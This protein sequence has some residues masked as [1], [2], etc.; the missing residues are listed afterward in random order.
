MRTGKTADNLHVIVSHPAKQGNIYYR[1]RAAQAMGASV[2][3]LTGL[4]YRPDRLPYSLV[5]FLPAARRARMERLL[6]K[7]RIEGLSP[8]NVTTL[9]GPVLET[10]MRPM[11]KVREWFAVH[12]WLASRWLVRH[13]ARRKPVPTILHTFQEAARRTLTAARR[14]DVVRL[15]EVTLPPPPPDMPDFPDAKKSD[16]E[17]LKE[18]VDQAEFVL[19]QSEFSARCVAALGFAPERIIRCHL[20]V[21]TH[22]FR[23]RTGPRRPGPVRVVFLGGTSRRKGVHHLLQAWTELRLEGAEL[24][25]A[26]NRTGGLENAPDLPNC[27]FL[28]RIPD[29]EFL[30]FLQDADVLVHPSLAEG[31]CNV[32]YEALACGIPCIISTNASSAVRS[33]QEGFVFPTGNVPALK[34]ALHRVCADPELRRQMSETARKRAETL[35]W[36][37]YLVRLAAIYRGLA[38]YAAHRDNC[39]LQELHTEGF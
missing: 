34:L 27:R 36:E 4:Y 29:E 37:K 38:D 16:A 11:R 30:T 8:E 9:L 5:R 17:R 31:G 26:G 22:H 23:P 7:R 1:P 15:F 13:M 39:V 35:A 6:E 21:D 19:V 3:F 18:E 32:V 20:G 10:T 25:I 33:G 14:M 24:L 28:G 2:V 12:D